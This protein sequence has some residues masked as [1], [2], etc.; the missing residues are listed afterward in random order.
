MSDKLIGCLC[1]AMGGTKSNEIPKFE[2]IYHSMLCH[3]M[4][5]SLTAISRNVSIPCFIFSEFQLPKLCLC[6]DFNVQLKAMSP[7]S[8]WP[9]GLFF[10]SPLDL[11]VT[12]PIVSA[13][14]I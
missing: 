13:G 5:E 8:L 9:S 10:G 11:F 7:S 3:I 12:F 4:L 1:I 14:F 6:E 2:A